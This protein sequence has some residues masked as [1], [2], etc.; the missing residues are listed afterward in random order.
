[1]QPLVEAQEQKGQMNIKQSDTSLP[2]EVIERH[3]TDLRAMNNFQVR[4]TC[5]EVARIPE[6]LYCAKTTS[7]K[8][9]ENPVE[10]WPVGLTKCSRLLNSCH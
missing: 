2:P 1:M 10:F 7:A 4:G 9:L 5:S 3:K 8:F 6:D